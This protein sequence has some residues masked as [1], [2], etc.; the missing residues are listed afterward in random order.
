MPHL[1]AINGFAGDIL[2]DVIDD[3]IDFY[4]AA[5]K[6]SAF[7]LCDHILDEACKVGKTTDLI[8]AQTYIDTANFNIPITKGTSE[9][10]LCRFLTAITMYYERELP[11]GTSRISS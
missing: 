1:L 6:M 10:P 5:Q 7:P 2:D 3:V 4:C 8:L 9:D 11:Q